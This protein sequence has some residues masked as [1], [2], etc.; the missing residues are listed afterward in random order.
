MKRTVERETSMDMSIRLGRVWW[1]GF[2][3]FCRWC[4]FGIVLT[5][6]W[7]PLAVLTN[8]LGDSTA[9]ERAVSVLVLL[10]APIPFYF[11]SKYLCLLGDGNRPAP[12]GEAGPSAGVKRDRYPLG[13]KILVSTGAAFLAGCVLSPPDP[14]TGITTGGMMALLCGVSLVILARFA[15]MKSASRPMQTLVCALV[16][17]AAVLSMLC[18]FYGLSYSG[19]L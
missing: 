8:F 11:A 1:T 18:L 12:Q 2:K 6:L 3:V 17:L 15:F 19:R 13:M 5:L 16:C 9:C 4:A 7:L 14:L 10:L